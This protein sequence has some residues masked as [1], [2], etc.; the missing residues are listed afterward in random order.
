MP[1]EVLQKKSCG[2]LVFR[3]VN[4]AKQFLLMKHREHRY[5]LPKGHVENNE[6]EQQTALRELREETGI[7]QDDITLDPKFRYEEKYTCTYARF[8]GKKINKT[9]VIFLGE[10][11]DTKK[12]IE[13]TEHVDFVW[14]DW[15]PPHDI[16]KNTINPL[17]K[18]VEDFW[19]SKKQ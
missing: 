14:M 17:L 1:E 7:T 15:K 11:K 3:T 6:T 12:K 2:V 19:K 8:P 13:V 4:N 10:L 5:D 18:H 16:Q 9:L